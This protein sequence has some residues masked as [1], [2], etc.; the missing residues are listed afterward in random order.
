MGSG[1]IEQTVDLQSWAEDIDSREVCLEWSGY[2]RSWN[3]EADLFPSLDIYDGDGHPVA[4]MDADKIYSTDWEKFEMILEVAP[5]V[6]QFRYKAEGY[7]AD[8]G[9]AYLSMPVLHLRHTNTPGLCQLP[10]E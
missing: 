6:R 10:E 5:G 9:Q 1:T 8:D 3:G 2:G 4:N 7:L